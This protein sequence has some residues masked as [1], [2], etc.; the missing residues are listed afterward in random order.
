MFGLSRTDFNETTFS[1][2]G[3]ELM[4]C[5]DIIE[6]FNNIIADEKS[7]KFGLATRR[8]L[9]FDD[10]QKLYNMQSL[11][12]SRENDKDRWIMKNYLCDL[13]DTFYSNK[14]IFIQDLRYLYKK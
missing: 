2:F 10:I 3:E 13:I 5:D 9:S 14:Q 7:Y 4:L 6:F 1:C 12:G 11:D 8:D